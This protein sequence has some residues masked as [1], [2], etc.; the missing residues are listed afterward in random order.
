[1][2]TKLI[3]STL[4]FLFLISSSVFAQN[5]IGRSRGYH[6]SI[7]VTDQLG[8]FVG[9]ETSHGYMFDSHNYIGLGIGGFILPNDS[10]PIYMNTFIDYHNYLREKN[11]FVL[12]L[13]AGWSHAFNYLEDS[14]IQ[15]QNGV[16][17][18][19]NAGWSWRLK[20]G[21][22]LCL[23][24]GASMILPLGNSRT[25]RKILPLPKISFGFEF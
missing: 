18:E 7:A 5:G 20:S 1:M 25:S 17:F 22:G 11:T 12:G 14:G 15:Y 13:K 23:G 19:P 10:L 6:G 2:K 24:L 16:L 21:N 9:A 4:A 3:I 8:V